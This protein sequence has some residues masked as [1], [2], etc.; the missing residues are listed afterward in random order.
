MSDTVTLPRHEYNYLTSRITQLERV[1]KQA[2]EEHK[3]PEESLEPPY[4][5]D[6]WWEWAE[7]QADEDIRT[8][9]VTSLHNEEEINIFFDNL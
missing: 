1:V 4:G 2:V 8:G 6:A 9:R 3:L 5:T 7:R